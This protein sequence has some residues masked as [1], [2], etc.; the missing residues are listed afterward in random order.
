MRTGNEETMSRGEEPITISDGSPIQ[1]KWRD[2]PWT[3]HGYE[4]WK[5]DP[6]GHKKAVKR[7]A[8]NNCPHTPIHSLILNVHFRYAQDDGT[9][10]VL[11]A[12]TKAGGTNL[13][14]K[15][16]AGDRKVD[17][18][19]HF[20]LNS[21]TSY[22]GREDVAVTS[23]VA[24]IAAVLTASEGRSEGGWGPLARGGNTVTIL[25]GLTPAERPV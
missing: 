12:Y 11:T 18:R 23:V 10:Y 25:Y 15:L 7:L 13:K 2:E 17:F 16:T 6:I 1:I 9:E 21:P 5:N 3:T 14:I 19:E 24:R 8:L 20:T 22:I 4:I